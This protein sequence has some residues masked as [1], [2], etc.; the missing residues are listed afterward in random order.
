MANEP[1]TTGKGDDMEDIGILKEL[2]LAYKRD[3]K[4][5]YKKN[6]HP[7]DTKESL[8]KRSSALQSA[9]AFFERERHINN[10]G[11]E[12]VYCGDFI[13]ESEKNHWEKCSKHP[14]QKLLRE[15]KELESLCQLTLKRYNTLKLENQKLLVEMEKLQ[16]ARNIEQGAWEETKKYQDENIELKKEIIELKANKIPSI[17]N[18][19]ILLFDTT[20]FE[21]DSEE[22][23]RIDKIRKL[24]KGK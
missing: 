20:Y 16:R 21:L 10:G 23:R 19:A 5:L 9:I 17:Y 22:K 14:A 7:S 8:E 24:M 13:H 3:L 18:L 11:F 4:F 6:P 2:L 15:K 1:L 12:C